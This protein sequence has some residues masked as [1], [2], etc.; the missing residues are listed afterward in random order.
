M[1]FH[2]WAVLLLCSL[3]V[4]MK[5][6]HDFSKISPYLSNLTPSVY[7]WILLAKI[8]IATFPLPHIMKRWCWC[9]CSHLLLCIVACK[10]LLVRILMTICAD[11]RKTRR[12]C[13]EAFFFIATTCIWV[14]DSLLFNL[15]DRSWGWASN[16]PCIYGFFF[17]SCSFTAKQLTKCIKKCKHWSDQF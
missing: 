2:A 12:L 6:S 7:T 3:V 9:V 4:L 11:H 17:F 14:F 5:S 1:V 13:F 16:F 15:F 8:V 10:C